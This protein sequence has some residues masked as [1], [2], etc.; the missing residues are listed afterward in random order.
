L[1]ISLGREEGSKA[2]AM[3]GIVANQADEMR[4]RPETLK[5]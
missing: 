1:P 4:G 3:T 2:R 5:R